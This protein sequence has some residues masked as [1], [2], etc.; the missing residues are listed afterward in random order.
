L[1]CSFSFTLIVPDN[2][3][4]HDRHPFGTVS[5]EL[6][7]ILEGTPTSTMK[8]LKDAL[9]WSRSPSPARSRTPSRAR[10]AIQPLQ[11][12]RRVKQEQLHD[13][14]V[15][16]L[17][18]SRRATKNLMVIHNPRPSGGSVDLDVHI[19]RTIENAGRFD[20]HLWSKIVSA[21]DAERLRLKRER[22]G[23]QSSYCS[24]PLVVLFTWD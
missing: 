14:A 17:T 20:V 10:Q 5:H 1:K 12:T 6:Y 16:Q 9:P 3:I 15:G 13:D 23:L 8:R 18:G 11:A 19:S 21:V 22:D 24:S 7:A 2:M 4:A